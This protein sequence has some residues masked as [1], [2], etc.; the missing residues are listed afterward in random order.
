MNQLFDIETKILFGQDAIEQLDTID[1][2]KVILVTDTSM[3]KFGLTRPIEKALER[4][5]IPFQIF[6][7]VLPDPS[8]DI[9]MEGMAQVIDYKPDTLI[10]LGGGSS[11]DSA[12]AMVY[13]DL[14]MQ[15]K[16][17]GDGNLEKKT[18]IAIPTTSGTG[19]EVTCYSVI[20]DRGN[21]R[22]I[23][24]MDDS[25]IPDYA[26]LDPDFTK[27]LPQKVIADSGMD[28]LTHAM[29][30]YVSP[31]GTPFSR[32]MARESIIL[33]RDHLKKMYHDVSQDLNREKMHLASCLGGLAFEKSSLGLNHGM[34][35]SLGAH[36][37]LAHGRCNALLL[38]Y[39]IKFNAGF[40]GFATEDPEV[41]RKYAEIAELFAY[42]EGSD[43][44][45]VRGLISTIEQYN[46][47]MGIPKTI[48]QAGVDKES[49]RKELSSLVVA[50]LNDGCTPGNPVKVTM[51]DVIKI[52]INA[53]A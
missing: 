3:V 14:K 27:T 30:A 8:L 11:I 24:L 9:V 45:K 32:A 52:Y 53:Y 5:K 22:K 39:V 6:D 26:I 7:K 1:M 18:L 40:S 15:A 51:E 12:K 36:F 19:S 2:K 34:A 17:L 21:N 43:Q 49:F 50:A 42:M 29:E 4:R 41:I 37:H 20:T 23:P 47:E 33:V 13:F 46:E 16:I 10:A 31:K 25:M 48:S 38:P 44:D 28:V 35:H